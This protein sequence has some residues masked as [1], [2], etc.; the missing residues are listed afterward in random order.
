M[1]CH[2]AVVSDSEV[3]NANEVCEVRLV[4]EIDDG[5]DEVSEVDYNVV[6]EVGEADE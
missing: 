5:L 6:C 4:R 1:Q 2:K 3:H